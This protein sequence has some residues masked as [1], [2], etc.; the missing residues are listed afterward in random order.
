MF[1]PGRV[2]SRIRDRIH[3][4]AQVLILLG[5]LLALEYVTRTGMVDQLTLS[6][7]TDILAMT[8]DL[9]RDE[10]IQD[11][12]VF[13]VVSFAYAYVLAIVVGILFGGLLWRSPYVRD[14][15]DPYLTVYYASPH[16]VFYPYL[17]AVFGFGRIPIVL[18]AFSM[19][20]IVIALNTAVGLTS[21]DEKYVQVGRQLRL[22]R[23]QMLRHIYAHAAAPTVF[24]GLR[25]GF[26]Y[27][28][29]GVIASEF[30]LA[31]VGVGF[32]ISFFYDHFQ[33]TEMYALIVLVVVGAIIANTALIRTEDALNER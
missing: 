25:L 17:I 26:V 28:V 31:N 22:S 18:I 10:T 32:R 5:L 13:S 15:L 2:R 3:N 4:V 16:F 12:I 14:V 9:V 1:R 27:A 11:D 20:V 8:T 19:S 30:I 21:V 23:Y 7:P 24:S 29:I 33:T 6:P